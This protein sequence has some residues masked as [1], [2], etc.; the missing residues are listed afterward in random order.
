MKHTKS[1]KSIHFYY[2]NQSKMLHTNNI[3]ILMTGW[4]KSHLWAQLTWEFLEIVIH[5]HP[6]VK[7]PF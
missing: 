7:N 5:A 4:N 3:L 6:F 2:H 1:V